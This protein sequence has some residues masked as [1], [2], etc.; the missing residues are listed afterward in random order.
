[1]SA[2]IRDYEILHS[3]QG[4]IRGQMH[5]VGSAAY[6]CMSAAD[7]TVWFYFGLF[8]NVKQNVVSV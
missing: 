2:I 1:M 5:C 7:V 6:T 4:L 3:R 8:E